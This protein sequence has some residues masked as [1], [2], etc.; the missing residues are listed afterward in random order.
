MAVKI[1]VKPIG[2]PK[3]EARIA[4]T[5]TPADETADLRDILTELAATGKTSLSDDASRA[6]YSFLQRILGPQQAQK[7]MTYMFI[8]NQR[9]E[10][11]G[12]PTEAR[13][14]QFYD[15][16]AG[17]EEINTTLKRVKNLGYGVLPGY[18][19]SADYTLQELAG[20]IPTTTAKVDPA[21][22]KIKLR[23]GEKMQ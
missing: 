7:M 9:P 18:R 22:Q 8:H 3:E 12:L 15:T 21:V 2:D 4:K 19:T 11:K 16:P 10:L 23:V 20:R 1:K 13:I 17:D 6:S 5:R 14:K